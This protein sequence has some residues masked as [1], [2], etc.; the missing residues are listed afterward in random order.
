MDDR[1]LAPATRDAYGRAARGYLVFLESRGIDGLDGADGGSVLGFLES[2]SG[3]WAASSL[4]WVVSNFRPFLAFTGRTDLVDAAGL[5]GARRSHS[6]LPVLSDDDEEQVVQACASEVVSAR[7]AA[8]TL[9]ALTTG[10]R[11]CD[12]VALRLG[13]IDW[14]ARTAGIV[15]QK[16]NNPLTV[17]LTALLAANLADYVLGERPNSPDDH[18]FLRCLAPNTRLAD[19]A[20]IYRVITEVF[21]KA[22]VT[23]VRAGTRLLRHNAASRLLRAAVPLPTIS[24]VLGHASPES[25]NSYLSVDRDRLLECV[26]DVPEAARS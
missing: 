15:Q 22:G 19:H 7:D 21:C 3:R 10:L 18:V 2:L 14:R 11:A 4:F 13:D 16:T 17:P 6:I 24:A 12:I 8:I 23:H 5:A 1:G 9:L 25:T 20:S 26:L